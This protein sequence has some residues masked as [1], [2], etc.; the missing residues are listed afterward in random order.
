MTEVACKKTLMGCAD[1]KKILMGSVLKVTKN[2]VAGG[3]YDVTGL[4][5]CCKPFEGGNCSFLFPGLDFNTALEKGQW[6]WE[7]GRGR[8]KEDDENSMERGRCQ[9]MDETER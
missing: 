6:G 3:S 4:D 5:F 7:E 8:K 2:E 1:P 9:K